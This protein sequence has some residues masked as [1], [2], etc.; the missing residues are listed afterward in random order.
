MPDTLS[1]SG[2][3]AALLGALEVPEAER[4][5]LEST[6]FRISRQLAFPISEG[7]TWRASIEVEDFACGTTWHS[8]EAEA[9]AGRI[10]VSGYPQLFAP[11]RYDGQEIND[12]SHVDVTFWDF[13]YAQRLGTAVPDEEQVDV[14]ILSGETRFLDTAR[15][16]DCVGDLPEDRTE[17]FLADLIARTREGTVRPER[18]RLLAD[19]DVFDGAGRLLGR[20]WRIRSPHRL[21]DLRDQAGAERIE[22]W[23]ESGL[24]VH[25]V[26]GQRLTRE[27]APKQ[28]GR[29]DDILEGITAQVAIDIRPV[30]APGT[31][32]TYIAT[33]PEAPPFWRFHRRGIAVG[34]QAEILALEHER[35]SSLAPAPG[36]GT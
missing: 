26:T 36:C 19:D 12:F 35:R 16:A 5:L 18:M 27:L 3:H 32:A 2:L 24:L 15:I 7:F 33:L 14:A 28:R 22:A 21:R 6:S 11:D 4:P 20:E 1:P 23:F 13:D 31:W 30:I 29:I 34:W 25:G 8:R 9:R 10:R 17:T